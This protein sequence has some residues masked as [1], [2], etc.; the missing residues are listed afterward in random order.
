VG[1]SQPVAGETETPASRLSPDF[2]SAHASEEASRARPE[3]G[4]GASS[5]ANRT[6]VGTPTVASSAHSS[7]TTPDD[8][9]VI[10]GVVVQGRGACGSGGMGA[11]AL[12][13]VSLF[14]IKSRE[15]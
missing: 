11:A 3:A 14:G 7:A 13:V 9:E 15:G 4:S 5:A 2:D 10:V 1:E 12:G 6:S 8:G